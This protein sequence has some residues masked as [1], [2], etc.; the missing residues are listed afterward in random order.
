[1]G[2]LIQYLNT[3]RGSYNIGWLVTAFIVTTEHPIPTDIPSDC[4]Q[5][6]LTNATSYNAIVA[7]YEQYTTSSAFVK[8]GT[9]I[10]VSG[11]VTDSWPID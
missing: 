10:D 8:N 2:Y 11:P 9:D 1:M 3:A 7:N 4:T 5:V 6:E